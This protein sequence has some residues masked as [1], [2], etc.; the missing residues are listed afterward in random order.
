MFLIHTFS[1]SNLQCSW[2]C[3]GHMPPL[4]QPREGLLGPSLH[5][6]ASAVK[7]FQSLP[8]SPLIYGHCQSSDGAELAQAWT[9]RHILK[10]VNGRRGWLPVKEQVTERLRSYRREAPWC[11]VDGL[12]GTRLPVLNAGHARYLPWEHTGK[13][14]LAR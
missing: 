8:S 9:D 1:C 6:S 5:L 2:Y 7:Q 12:K 10:T 3:R 13:T 14:P 4:P 11:L